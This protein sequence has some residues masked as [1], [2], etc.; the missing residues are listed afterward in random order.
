[1]ERG[2]L[3]IY[4]PQKST[5]VGAPSLRA[6]LGRRTVCG[7]TEQRRPQGSKGCATKVRMVLGCFII[8]AAALRTP[9]RIGYNAQ[10][11]NLK[12]IRTG[13]DLGLLHSRVC[14]DLTG[15]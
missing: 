13:L 3:S 10:G 11:V 15:G 1:M 4:L 14:M 5:R 12:S 2:C 9:T 7:S 8:A 6:S